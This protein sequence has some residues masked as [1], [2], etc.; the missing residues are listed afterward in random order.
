[1]CSEYEGD[2][3]AVVR[4][5]AYEA[6]ECS[7]ARILIGYRFG[8]WVD[9]APVLVLLSGGVWIY[10]GTGG[11]GGQVTYWFITSDADFHSLSNDVLT[12]V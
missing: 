7:T 12:G 8:L 3:A 5:S 1:M 10:M 6:E 9:E 4:D 2:C 11:R